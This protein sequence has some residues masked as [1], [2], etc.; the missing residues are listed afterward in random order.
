[1]STAQR[2]RSFWTL[3]A[4]TA[5]ESLRLYFEPIRRFWATSFIGKILA[6]FALSLVCQYLLVH[7]RLPFSTD[8]LATT[9]ATLAITGAGTLIFLAVLQ[10]VIAKNL[11][12]LAT[13]AAFVVG[14]VTVPIALSPSATIEPI[15]GMNL[16]G[17]TEDIEV[18]WRNT[19]PESSVLVLVR[20]PGEHGQVVQPCKPLRNSRSGMM[21]CRIAVRR[22]ADSQRVGVEVRVVQIP[23]ATSEFFPYSTSET[24]IDTLPNGSA[25]LAVSRL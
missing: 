13:S 19:A 1:M 17:D 3:T 23:G 10:W 5:A 2:F 22:D 21:T 8:G 18:S 16:E 25:L 20:Y 7:L 6:A 14:M 24:V 9:G 4:S 11:L 12:K 15:A